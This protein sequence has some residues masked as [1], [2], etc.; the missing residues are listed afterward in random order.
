MNELQEKMQEVSD[1]LNFNKDLSG[2]V[3]GLVAEVG[4]LADVVAKLNGTKKI[5]SID[6]GYDLATKFKDELADV[7]I[8]VLQIAN[9]QNL[10]LSEICSDKL[11]IVQGRFKPEEFEE[12]DT[13]EAKY[14]WQ[15]RK[16]RIE[17]EVAKAHATYI[18]RKDYSRAI[19][20]Q[21]VDNENCVLNPQR[22]TYL[23]KKHDEY[24]LLATRKFLKNH[25]LTEEAWESVLAELEELDKRRLI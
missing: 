9:A 8:Y 23:A 7:M 11:E 2:L 4:E 3:L 14:D 15:K 25:N 10:N 5:K 17:F 19:L 6:E 20:E 12:E 24:I 13:K 16:L 1:E 22:D 21:T 18:F